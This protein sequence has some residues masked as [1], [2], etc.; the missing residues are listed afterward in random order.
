MQN[1]TQ[2]TFRH[3]LCVYPYRYDLKRSNFFPPLGLEYVAAAIRPYT[4]SIDLVDLRQDSRV[5]RDFVRPDTDLIL[6]SVNW[7]LNV[8][9]MRREVGSTPKE[10]P[11]ILGG[12]HASEDPEA[13]LA[14]FPNV[15][16]VVRGDGEEVMAEFGSKR[17]FAGI[18]GISYRENGSIIHNPNRILGP[19]N[20]ELRPARS[21]R[22][23]PYRVEIDGASTGVEIDMVSA[24]RGCPYNCTFCSFSRNPWGEKRKWTM[25]SPESVVDE[26]SQLTAPV[27]GFTD[28]IFSYDMDYVDKLCNLIQALGIRKIFGCNARLEIA[29]RPDVLKKMGET[30]FFLLLLGIES[31]HDKTLHSMRKGFNTAKI[32]EYFEI[33]RQSPMLLHGYFILGNIGESEEDMEQI[34]P[35]AHELGVDTIALSLLR[36]SPFSGLDQLV[37]DSPGYHIAENSKIYSDELSLRDLKDLRRRLYRKFYTPDQFLQLVRKGIRNNFHRFLPSVLLHSPN[38]AYHLL[39]SALHRKKKRR[40]RRMAS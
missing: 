36:A 6:F 25:R 15:D 8:D 14:E 40:R 11:T 27:V 22:R 1:P 16:A 26:I 12:R 5:T 34:V 19:I 23:R 35:F 29:K 28:D 18:A 33:I 3:V 38:I 31:A 21:L 20:E 2:K 32:R 13:W 9:F 30:G 24:S 7:K 37:A 4:E 39:S 17:T 10:I